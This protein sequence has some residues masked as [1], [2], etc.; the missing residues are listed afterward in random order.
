[1]KNNCSQTQAEILSSNGVFSRAVEEHCAECENCRLLKQDWTLFCRPETAPEVPLKNDFAVIRTA[2]KL[3]KSRKRQV[4]IRRVLGYT[5]AAA[6][7]I[8]ALYT[9]IFGGEMPRNVFYR[10]WN[11]D[12]FE[13][14]LFVLDTAAE[15][16]LLD[17]TVRND[18]LNQFIE[19]EIDIKG[20]I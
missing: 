8:A 4:M 17:I 10:Y 2:Q 3:A 20:E 1:M 19:K 7:G 13:E 5:A 6:S 9:V 16:S 11:W 14:K 18:P 12:S 15:V